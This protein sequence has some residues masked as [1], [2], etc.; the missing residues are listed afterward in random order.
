MNKIIEVEN[1]GKK[2]IISHQQERY[3]ALRDVMA[4]TA[5]K[6]IKKVIGRKE[7]NPKREEF[8]ALRNVDFEVSAGDRIG[9]I[10]RNGAG[11]STLLKILSRITEP[12]EGKVKIKGRLTSLLEVG[13]GFH[14]ELTGRENIF[15]NG[16]VLGMGKK[17]ILKKFD[18]IV[19][20]AGVEKFLDTPVKRYS[21]GM[22]VRLAFAV[23][24]NLEPEILI[25]DEVLA[26]GDASF[27]KKC[28]GKM[29]N[30]S[31]A[32]GKTVLFVSHNMG[33]ISVLCDRVIYLDKGKIVFDGNSNDGISLYQENDFRN[34]SKKYDFNKI[35]S[36]RYGTGKARFKSLD[37][38]ASNNDYNGIYTG[39]DLTVRVS[40]ES[41][42]FIKD[43]RVDVIFYDLNGYRIIDVSTSMKNIS[44][45][46]FSGNIKIYEFNLKKILLKPGDYFIGL[47]LGKINEEDIDGI[48]YVNKITIGVNPN[49]SDYRY[50]YPGI[51]QCTFDLKEL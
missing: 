43:A 28:L 21:S 23:A 10:G 44:V 38:F 39:G 22:Y 27:Q 45:D 14:Q 5:K 6:T 19:E 7:I 42:C 17:E 26:V 11:K 16:A 18:E 20:F 34:I 40:I 35:D 29:E 51:Y 12:T 24:A 25:V 48:Q 3:A 41:Y 13:T 31:K 2:Y 36:S 8:W 33:A 32:E 1:L 9:I 46:F 49:S 15:L 47:W 30:I 4:N 50:M 37:I